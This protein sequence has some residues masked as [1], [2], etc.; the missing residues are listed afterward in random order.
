MAC[1]IIIRADGNS[2]IGFGHIMRTQALAAQL[3]KLGAEVIFLTKNP[4]NVRDYLC[5]A[6]PAG[7]SLAEEDEWSAGY[8]S[9]VQADMLIRVQHFT[10]LSS[11]IKEFDG[12]C[13]YSH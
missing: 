11:G 7:I 4:E 12:F 8:L 6:I 9:N 5:Q 3:Q 1:K 13:R 10:L 2:E